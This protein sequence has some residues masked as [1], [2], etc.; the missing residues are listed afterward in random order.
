MLR[1]YGAR[2]IMQHLAVPGWKLPLIARRMRRLFAEE[3]D[4]IRP[5]AGVDAALHA[6]VERGV[7]LAIVSSNSRDNISRVLGPQTTALFAHFGCDVSVFGKRRIL[8]RVIR[9][10]GVPGARAIYVGDEIRDLEA[11]RGEGI[12]FGAVAWGY[13][14]PH[15]LASHSPDHLFE[16]FHELVAGITAAAS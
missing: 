11:A 14:L 2:R 15:A 9:E 1:G 7:A 3:L 10:A 5:F 12:A 13:T 4:Q 6:L 16:S 8:R